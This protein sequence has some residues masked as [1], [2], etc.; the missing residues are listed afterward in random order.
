[1]ETTPNTMPATI[2][3]RVLVVWY[4]VFDFRRTVTVRRQAETTAMRQVLVRIG[5]QYTHA[6]SADSW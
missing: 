6:L 1:V 5:Q 3:H 2:A 4:V